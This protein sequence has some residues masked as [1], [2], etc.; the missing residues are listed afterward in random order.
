[1]Y[2]EMII[3]YIMYMVKMDIIGGK[4]QIVYM[5]AIVVVIV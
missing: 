1:M 2:S 3:R 5:I 4:K